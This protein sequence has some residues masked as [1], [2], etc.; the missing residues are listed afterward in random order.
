M[1][2]LFVLKTSF[3]CADP[4]GTGASLVEGKR[5]LELGAGTGACGLA[6]AALGAAHVTLTDLPRLLPL[7]QQN[8]AVNPQLASRVVVATLIWGD[9]EAVTALHPPVDVVLASDCLYQ[10]AALQPF[11]ASLHALSGQQ[12]LT[13][14]SLEHRQALPFPEAAFQAAG[15]DVQRL[16]AAELDPDWSADDIHVYQI[17]LRQQQ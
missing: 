12:T 9:D 4:P 16:S 2:P 1:L 14:L 6:A 15:F 3:Q 8:V 7:L 11:L 10:A 13:L 17:H 5:V